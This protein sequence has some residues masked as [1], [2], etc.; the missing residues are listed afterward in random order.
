MSPAYIEIAK[1]MI[2]L[3][4]CILLDEKGMIILRCSDDC[5]KCPSYVFKVG[6]Q[7]GLALNKREIGLEKELIEATFA[8]YPLLIFVAKFEN[9]YGP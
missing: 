8:K 4:T 7:L 1:K 6:C 5:S 2:L 3:G 9:L